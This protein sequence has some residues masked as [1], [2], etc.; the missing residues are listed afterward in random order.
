M[1]PLTISDI[2]AERKIIR[3]EFKKLTTRIAQLIERNEELDAAE[4]KLVG[5]EDQ[6]D[7]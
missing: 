5:E 6:C 2:A 3:R 4:R 1:E 7:T